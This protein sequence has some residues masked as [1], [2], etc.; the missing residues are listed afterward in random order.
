MVPDKRILI[1]GAGP[2]GMISGFYLARQGIPV[3]IFE[4]DPATRPDH[5]ASTVHPSTLD[6][7][8]EL[9]VT[10]HLFSQGLESAIFQFRDRYDDRVVAGR[11]R[12]SIRAS[13]RTAQGH[14]HDLRYG[15]QAAGF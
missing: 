9:G 7:L 14:Q 6:M 13:G 15:D 11:N 10:E 12:P 2:V 3:T 4:A 5:R 1:A 8:N